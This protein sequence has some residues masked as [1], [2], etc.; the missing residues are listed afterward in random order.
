MEKHSCFEV[1]YR[2]LFLFQEDRLLRLQDEGRLESLGCF[3]L[4][5]KKETSSHLDKIKLHFWD[6]LAPD[7]GSYN[8]T[9]N[10]T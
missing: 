4:P 10:W 2:L 8:N 7:S 6:D 5:V 9:G 1:V 3:F